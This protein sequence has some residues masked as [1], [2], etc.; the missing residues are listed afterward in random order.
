MGQ[1]SLIVYK[2]FNPSLKF[3]DKAVV[4]YQI[5]LRENLSLHIISLFKKKDLHME[6][7]AVDSFS[8]VP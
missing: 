2:P 8:L 5:L 4:F 1:I 3:I 6:H 7:N